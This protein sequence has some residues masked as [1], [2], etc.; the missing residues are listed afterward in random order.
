MKI[1]PE[2]LYLRVLIAVL[3]AVIFAFFYPDAAIK[4]KPLGDGFIKLIKMVIGPLIFCTIVIGIV[5]MEDL[6]TMGRIGVKILIYF[7]VLTTIALIIGLIIGNLIKPGSAMNVDV[8]ALDSSALQ[9]YTSRVH[10]NNIVN[11]L[12]NIIP[13]TLVSALSEGTIL[14][15]LFV[16]LL[17]GFALHSI[18]EKA[19][20]VIEL[21]SQILEIL[22]KI[23]N[24]IMKLAPI[25]AFGAIAYTVG[26]YG[27]SSLV[28]LGFLI[29]TFYIT[30]ALFIFVV[31]G[32][33]THLCGFNIWK[34]LK[35]IKE[36]FFLVLGTSSSESALPSL[37]KKLENAGCPKSIVGITIP[38]GYSFNLDGTC[39]YFT[40][41]IIFIAQATGINLSLSQE[42]YIIIILLITSKGAAG[43]T[44]SGFIALAATLS[45][46]DTVPVAGLT[47]ILGIDRFMSEARALTNLVG[48]SVATMAIAK[49]EKKLDQNKLNKIL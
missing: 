16:A 36:E 35:Y 5:T 46:I 7:E 38:S 14:P 39:I 2:S 21:I 10:D 13:K 20:M 24:F 34:F 45:V 41:A 43:V 33:I 3:L 37:M 47:L 1:L 17:F 32:F 12:L 19:G 31:L 18:K 4:A 26:E 23:I 29:I 44:G 28:S 42:L 49:W 30:C 25:G 11:F 48:N 9:N 6:S 15:V 22:F 8:S 40:L 27:I